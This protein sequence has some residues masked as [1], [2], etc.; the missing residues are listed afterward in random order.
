MP[1]KLT[2]DEPELE[3]T[4]SGTISADEVWIWCVRHQI[5]TFKRLVG[6][7]PIVTGEESHEDGCNRL[8]RADH[9]EASAVFVN[10]SVVPV[11]HQMEVGAAGPPGQHELISAVVAMVKHIKAVVCFIACRCSEPS[12][13][14]ECILAC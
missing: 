7:D 5:I 10:F 11:V 6:V 1:P 14:N 4:L 9:H 3:Y 12:S 2:A 13:T 8:W